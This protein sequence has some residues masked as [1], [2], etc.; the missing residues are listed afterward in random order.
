MGSRLRSTVVSA[1]NTS[2]K[3]GGAAE[4]LPDIKTAMDLYDLK[5]EPLKELAKLNNVEF[6]HNI[7]KKDLYQLLMAH[8]NFSIEK[9]Q[10]PVSAAISPQV[11]CSE[12]L[13]TLVIVQEGCSQL[14][15]QMTELINLQTQVASLQTENFQ[16]NKTVADLHGQVQKLQSSFDSVTDAAEIDKKKCNLRVTRLPRDIKSQEAAAPFIGKMWD[17]LGLAT[18]P[19]ATFVPPSNSYASVTARAGK[20]NQTGSILVKCASVQEKFDA[21]KARKKLANTTFH[22]VGLDVD[23][24]RKQ[25]AARSASWEDYMQARKDKKRTY[26]KG[27]ELWVDGR[28]HCLATQTSSQPRQNTQTT[29]SFSHNNTFT[30]IALA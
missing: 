2:P 4:A 24:T 1:S 5:F 23:L 11:S 19:T 12:A 3:A 13:L 18:V 10:T 14:Q 30:P 26:W 20:T 25:Q 17:T 21:L 28:L 22:T 15:E 29:P 16:L 6:P 7:V 9:Q 27:G 8:F